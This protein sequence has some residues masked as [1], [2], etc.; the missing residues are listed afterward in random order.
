[1]ITLTRA[2]LDDIVE[3]AAERGAKKALASVGLHD[4]KAASDMRSLLAVYRTIRN[5]AASA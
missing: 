5:S 1:M 4:D 2:K 3:S